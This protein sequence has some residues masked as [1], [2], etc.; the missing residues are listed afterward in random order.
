MT[1]RLWLVLSASLLGAACVVHTPD[2]A[3]WDCVYDAQT[4]G[5]HC[6]QIARAVY[7]R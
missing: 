7:P 6:Q 5:I 1:I 3:A 4:S 2:G